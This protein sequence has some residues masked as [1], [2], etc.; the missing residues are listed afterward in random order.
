MECGSVYSN[1]G[2]VE[3]VFQQFKGRRA[4]IIKALTTEVDKF[5]EKCDPQNGN[6][7]LFGYPDE[8]W[9]VNRPA[10]EVPPELPEPVLAIN[11]ARSEMQ[12]N[13]WL[14]L[15]AAHSD[16]WL[17]AVSSYIG[18]RSGFNKNDRKQLFSMINELPTICEITVANAKKQETKDKSI[19]SINNN[20]CSKS[21]SNGEQLSEIQRQLKM[22]TA[23]HQETIQELVQVKRELGRLNSYLKQRDAHDLNEGPMGQNGQSIPTYVQM[24]NLMKKM[25][26]E[27]ISKD[28]EISKL[29]Q[30]IQTSQQKGRKVPR[31]S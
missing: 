1:P 6:L 19:L 2:T 8:S 5:Y 28:K 15:V 7:C 29:H 10:D 23:Q 21:K 27:M 26:T 17:L 4:G 16:A 22:L 11:F 9:D 3:K 25:Q 12:R 31:W 30:L 18:A 24:E 14:A 20:G 13:D